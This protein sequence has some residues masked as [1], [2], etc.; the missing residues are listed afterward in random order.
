MKLTTL[1]Y[2]LLYNK[3]AMHVESVL[4][5]QDPDII[6]FQEILTDEQSLE[7][8]QRLGYRL[9]DFSNSFVRG[10]RI[11]GVATFY[12]PT[13]VSLTNSHIFS[14][15]SSLYQFLTYI[16]K[17]KKYPRTVLKNEFVIKE[18]G[19]KITTYNIHLTPVA[20]NGLRM[21]QIYSTFS[22]LDLQSKEAVLIAGD[23]NYPYGRKRFESMIAD[24]GLDEATSN[25]YFTHE[26]RILG[27]FSIRL[28]LDYILFKNMKLSSN[29]KIELKHSDHYPILSK[30]EV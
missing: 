17:N 7:R 4:K 22:D 29:Q 30:F 27:L 9:A 19:Q 15:P 25:V 13:V 26:R 6:F 24:Y 3:A 28:K 20:T 18:T 16:V 23:F 1:T 5:E 14:L 21:K 8:I 10:T 11:F 12:K 2:N